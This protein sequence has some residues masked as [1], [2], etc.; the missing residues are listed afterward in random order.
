MASPFQQQALLRKLAYT[1]LILVLFTAAWVWRH[2]YVDAQAAQLAFRES[3]RGEVELTGLVVRLSLTGSRGLATCVLWNEALERQKKNQWNELELLTRS[4]TKLQP[5]YIVPW[6]FQTWNLA[7]NVSVE[8]DRPADK[9]F[10]ITRGITLL[11][12]GERVNRDNPDLRFALGFY[13]QHKVM[14]SDETNFHRSLFQLSLIPPNERDPGRFYNLDENQ[15][16]VFDPDRWRDFCQQ[17]PQL[18]RRLREGMHR[19]TRREQMRQF[20]CETTEDALRFLA[21]NFRVPGLY[22]EAS[23]SPPGGW[24][25]RRPDRVAPLADRFPPMPPPRAYPPGSPL[26]VFDPNELTDEKLLRSK[27][28]EVDGHAAARAWYG[29]A[30]EPIPAPGDLPGKTTEITDRARQRLPRN[31]TTLLFRHYPARSQSYVGERLAQ[32]GWFDERGWLIPGWFADD[33]FP[34]GVPAL[35]GSGQENW[36]REAWRRAHELWREHGE[37]NHLKISTEEEVNL[38]AQAKEFAKEFGLPEGSRPPVLRPEALEARGPRV[39]ELHHAAQFLFDYNYYRRLSNFA[40]HFTVAGVEAEDDALTARKAFYDAERLRLAGSP[41][42]ALNGYAEKR[43]VKTEAGGRPR[44][45]EARSGWGRLLAAVAGKSALGLWRDEILLK[46]KDYRRDDLVQEDAYEIQFRYL[47]LFNDQS[48]RQLKDRLA[49][50]AAFVPLLVP[51]DAGDFPGSI[52]PGP[53]DGADAEGVPL[54]SAHIRDI[55]DQRLVSLGVKAPPKAA[56][57]PSAGPPAK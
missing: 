44:W 21:E 14:Q 22:E 49:R 39:V 13:T 32:E 23:P 35:V 42:R 53:F 55:V 28:D 30:Q 7:Y 2:Y 4:L 6:L 46:N 12:E 27:V 1:A 37:R 52:I 10:F 57:Q 19:E 33:R 56:P 8:A 45:A 31:M 47:R 51:M 54:I 25:E 48:G 18:V 16:P 41:Q 20:T 11:A 26:S 24:D 5:H 40:H 36:G 34:G 29:Y 17:H 9:Y 43:Y 38:T 3:D 50:A 15:R